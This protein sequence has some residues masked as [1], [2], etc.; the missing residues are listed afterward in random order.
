MFCLKLWIHS[1]SP[2]ESEKILDMQSVTLPK[3]SME[4]E[5]HGFQK[6]VPF[7]GTSF[8]VPCQISGCIKKLYLAVSR[9]IL[10]R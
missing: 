3:F 2:R 7:P 6:D 8:Q 4:P 10:S 9:V 1:Q 5:N